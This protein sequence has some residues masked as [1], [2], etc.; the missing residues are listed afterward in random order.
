VEREGSMKAQC[1]F[2]HFSFL[3][4]LFHYVQTTTGIVLIC[5]EIKCS[6]SK[7]EE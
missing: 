3:S 1:T 5:T 6:E 2:W 4:F 7:G